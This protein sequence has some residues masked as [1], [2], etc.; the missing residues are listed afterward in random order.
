MIGRPDFCRRTKSFTLIELLVVVAVIAIL[1][2]I[3]L[4]ALQ[5]SKEVSKR[6]VCMQHLRQVALATLV[7]AD[8]NDGWIN[9]TGRGDSVP[10]IAQYWL[11]TITNY[12][13]SPKLV[14]SV[15][16][17]EKSAACPDL[18]YGWWSGTP[19]GANTAFVYAQ[20][21]TN[22]LPM[23]PLTVVRRPSTTFLVAESYFWYPFFNDGFSWTC[24][25]VDCGLNPWCIYPRHGRQGLNF[26]FVDG[27]GEF[28]KNKTWGPSSGWGVYH[29]WGGEA[30]AGF[31]Y[32]IWGP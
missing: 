11:Y 20:D 22:N 18:K 14:Q 17:G 24:D 5:N 30:P 15:Y 27:H 16:I 28:M 26:V 21:P 9:G 8:E 6:Q 10:A 13:G 1:A 12:L 3:L 2:A 19:Y 7:M 25:G 31:P 32:N 29:Q 4:P 23:Q